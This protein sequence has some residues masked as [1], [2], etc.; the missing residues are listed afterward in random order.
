MTATAV[1][2]QT[3]LQTL[4]RGRAN[5]TGTTSTFRGEVL[6]EKVHWF[7][8][9]TALEDGTPAG[10]YIVDYLKGHGANRRPASNENKLM[11]TVPR[12]ANPGA[13]RNGY[14]VDI[15]AAYPSIYR[16][17]WWDTLFLPQHRIIEKGRIPLEE[18]AQVLGYHK[19]ARNALVGIA[20]SRHKTSWRDGRPV[21]VG[22]LGGLFNPQ[23]G[24]FCWSVL[25]WVAWQA[26]RMGARY[27]N[28]DGGIFINERDALRFADWLESVG[29]N[30]S[31]KEEGA[32]IVWGNGAYT[33]IR[34]GEVCGVPKPFSGISEHLPDASISLQAFRF[35]YG[36]E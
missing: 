36:L 29:F 6:G 24:W 23:L 18:I 20:L 5:G 34:G 14:Y 8:S 28:T 4:I 9:L 22:A 1:D 19:H 3:A 21:R 10:A 31:C 16:R 15:K 12:F 13:W 25:G 32:V 11:V 35:W 17:V 30:W 26:K 27:W 33:F 2:W 7:D